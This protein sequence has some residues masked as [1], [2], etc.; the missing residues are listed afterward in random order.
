MQINASVSLVTD[1][2]FS[3]LPIYLVSQLKMD[4]RTKISISIVLGL[5]LTTAGVNIAR[6]KYITPLASWEDYTCMHLS[7]QLLPLDLG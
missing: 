6:F 2:I 7:H 4:K 1:G 3:I 5:G